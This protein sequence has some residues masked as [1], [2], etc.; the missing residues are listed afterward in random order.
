MTA[1]HLLTL[2]LCLLLSA[3]SLLSDA[4]N[5]DPPQ[6]L[7]AVTGEPPTP[8]PIMPPEL[9]GDLEIQQL[10]LFSHTR[11]QRLHAIYSVL[12]YPTG[13]VTAE[14]DQQNVQLWIELPAKFKVVVAAPKGGP[15]TVS[16]S[17]G[18]TLIDSSGQQQSLPPSILEPFVPPN[19]PSDSVEPYPL[20]GMLGSP[21]SDLVFPAGLAQRGGEYHQTGVEMV[22]GRES[23]VVEWRREPAVLVDRFWVDR[24]TGVILRQQNYG[25]E[26][27]TSPLSDYQCTYIE[28][29]GAIPAETF[30]LADIPTPAPSSQ[31]PLPGSAIVT[32]KTETGILNVRSAPDTAS[33]IIT[34][35]NAG[36]TAIV[37]GK[38]TAGDWWQIEVQGGVGWVFGELVDF[39]GDV[40]SVPVVRQ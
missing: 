12:H 6:S 2:I 37:L 35:L 27:S 23:Y 25:K 5:P 15:Q 4:P 36:Q 39:K 1:K 18:V 3:C 20:S 26:N 40:E 14:P 38:N 22:A 19:T 28:I 11:W 30:N 21:V 29:D 32:V 24:Q 16:I 13:G 7:I 8:T 17:D 33:K 9:K 31:P 10:M 34:T